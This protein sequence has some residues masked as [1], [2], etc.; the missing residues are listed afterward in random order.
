MA[1]GPDTSFTTYRDVQNMIPGGSFEVSSGVWVSARADLSISTYGAQQGSYS[2][3]IQPNNTGAAYA[4]L[5]VS[6]SVGQQ[7]TMTAYIR[8]GTAQTG[9]LDGDSRRLRA[10]AT[11]N[12]VEMVIARSNQAPN[13][14]STTTKLTMTFTVPAGSTDTEV[15]LMNGATNSADNSV[16][17]D[18]VMLVE[19]NGLDTNGTALAYFDGNTA[20]TAAYNYDWDDVAGLSTSSRTALIDRSPDALIWQPGTNGI[21]FLQPIL[22]ATGRRLFQDLNGTWN[23]ADNNYR[24]SGQTR[25]G[26]GYGLYRVTDLASRT[27][28]Q[29][30]G[31]PLFA[32]AVILNYAWTESGTGKEKTARDVAGP[33]SYTKAYMPE[34]IQA[35]PTRDQDGRRTCCRG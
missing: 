29:T 10:V 26:Y 5:P 24:V 23:L 11:V 6:L 7:Y 4:I 32:D 16:Y 34:T 2:L 14:A 12:G 8:I 27:A 21:A 28:T 35:P 3:R 13:T 1:S 33:S 22:Q 30:D 9:S 19:G 31:L 20:D 15:R 17:Y 18:S 25:I